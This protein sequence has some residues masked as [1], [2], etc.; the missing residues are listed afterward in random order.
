MPLYKFKCKSCGNEFSKL[1]NFKSGSYECPECGGEARRLEINNF[2]TRYSDS[3]FYITD[4][5]GQDE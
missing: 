4:Y 2:T 3:G 5:G 1:A